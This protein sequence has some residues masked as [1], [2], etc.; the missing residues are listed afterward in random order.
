MCKGATFG[1]RRSEM[2]VVGRGLMVLMP[3]PRTIW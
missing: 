1:G 3:I 2:D